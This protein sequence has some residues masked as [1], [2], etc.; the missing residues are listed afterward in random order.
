MTAG[1]ESASDPAD[2]QAS[3]RCHLDAITE[4]EVEFPA[5]I[6]LLVEIELRAE[7]GLPIEVGLLPEV[8]LPTE[9]GFLVKVNL[10]PVVK[11]GQRQVDSVSPRATVGAA[12]IV[13]PTR[14]VTI[15]AETP[16]LLRETATSEK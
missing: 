12:E 5:E 8:E 10:P 16:V 3:G 14:G 15:P 11:H 6:E 7:V 2:G 13:I 9:V 4:V 1:V